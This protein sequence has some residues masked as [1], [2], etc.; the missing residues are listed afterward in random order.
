MSLDT[1]VTFLEKIC[2]GDEISWEQFKKIYSPLIRSCGFHW[3]LSAAECDELIQEVMISF[4]KRSKSFKYDRE[5]G[6]FR[7]YL[8]IIA[9]N[10]TFAMLKKRS[11]DES[12][13]NDTPGMLDLAFDEQWDAEWH[14][15]L[16][17]QALKLLQ[18]EMEA[19][20]FR[21]F[22]LY[23]IEGRSPAAVAAE[24]GIS[25]NAVYIN[26]S[27]AL[28]HLRRTVKMLNQL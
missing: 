28:E 24:L 13:V 19:V 7:S 6:S 23:V 21:A 16:Y 2:S 1:S 12:N 8:R 18:N 9:R 3:K 27:R 11:G 5:K 25:V 15:H 20:S 26:K 22:Y 17:V 14:N 4:F 10:A